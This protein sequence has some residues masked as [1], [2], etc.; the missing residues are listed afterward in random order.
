MLLLPKSQVVTCFIPAGSNSLGTVLTISGSGFD[1][2]NA[3]VWIGHTECTVIQVTGKLD[4][5]KNN[6][7]KNDFPTVMI[8]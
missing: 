4:K 7:G 1:D 8:L 6:H 5:N 2:G 3:T